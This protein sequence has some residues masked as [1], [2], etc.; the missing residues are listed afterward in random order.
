MLS[1][2]Q[3]V[4]GFEERSGAHTNTGK[5][6]LEPRVCEC[7]REGGCVCMKHSQYGYMHS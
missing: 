2:K 4:C 6:S 1:S 3:C 7:V 5:V